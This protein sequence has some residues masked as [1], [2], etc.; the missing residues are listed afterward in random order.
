MQLYYAKST[1]GFYRDDIHGAA[2]PADCVKISEALHQQLI[3]GQA[4]GQLM[5]HTGDGVPFLSGLRPSAM[6]RW[7]DEGWQLD[8]TGRHAE[9]VAE[10][11]LVCEVKITSGFRS[12]A[13]GE[14]Y[15][16]DSQVEDQLNLTGV[17]IAGLDGFYPCRDGQGK[18]DFRLHTF[19][20]IQQVGD[21]FTTFKLELLQKANNLKQRLDFALSA[22]DLAALEAVTWESEQP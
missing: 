6:H 9:K 8:L 3:T 12:A 11:S 16:Y 5:V 2:I 13:L 4:E 7:S 10:I 14:P 22:N 15:Q 1:A 17:I 19:A 21:D 20:Q 18:K